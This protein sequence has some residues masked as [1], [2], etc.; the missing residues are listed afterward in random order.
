PGGA[1]LVQFLARHRGVRNKQDLPPYTE[2]EILAWADAYHAR[3]GGWP[4]IESGPID[5]APGETW[6]AVQSALSNGH[7]GLPGGS[8]LARLRA[9]RRGVRSHLALPE[10]YVSQILTW[11]DA[12]YRRHGRWPNL[13]SGPV[14]D[15]PGE[16]WSA[17]HTALEQG[18]RGL[19]GGTSLAKLLARAR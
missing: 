7:R 11:A 2:E 14:E 9:R 13:R 4:M 5:E 16:R 12:H 3:T 19:P 8:S 15:A 10:L 1:S 18:H 17:V 6:S